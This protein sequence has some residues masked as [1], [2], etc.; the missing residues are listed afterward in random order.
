MNKDCKTI[1]KLLT[2]LIILGGDFVAC[3]GLNP[4]KNW[5]IRPFDTA[6]GTIA[7]AGREMSTAVPWRWP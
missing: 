7:I 5:E 3:D 6:I 1:F 2:V 4:S